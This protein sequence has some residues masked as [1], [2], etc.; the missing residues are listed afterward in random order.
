MDECGSGFS[1]TWGLGAPGL[2]GGT[3]CGDP[4]E[5]AQMEASPDSKD[6]RNH[7]PSYA[8]SRSNG[9]RTPNRSSHSS[10]SNISVA[11]IDFQAQMKSRQSTVAESGSRLGSRRLSSKPSKVEVKPQCY[12]R[13]WKGPLGFLHVPLS[14]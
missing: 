4:F 7:R 1:L 5:G 14:R 2:S 11:S 12:V 13:C 10:V 9:F 8:S 3:A 6:E